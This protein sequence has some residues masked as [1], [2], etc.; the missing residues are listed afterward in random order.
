M[1][2]IVLCFVGYILVIWRSVP[3]SLNTSEVNYFNAN[4][5]GALVEVLFLVSLPLYDNVSM[6][7][8]IMHP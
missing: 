2:M 8:T 1:T 6:T 4:F 3:Q 5:A 7:A